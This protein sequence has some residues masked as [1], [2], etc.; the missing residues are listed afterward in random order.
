M[1][2]LRGRPPSFSGQAPQARAGGSARRP[3][4][5]RT[6][7]SEHGLI[8]LVHEAGAETAPPSSG[9]GGRAFTI[10]ADVTAM[11]SVEQAVARTTAEFGHVDILHNNV[12]VTHMGGP[13]ELTEEQ[14]AAA[15]DLNI[16]PVYRT[17]KAVI[18]QALRQGGGAIVNISS[19][20]AARWNEDISILPITR[21]RQR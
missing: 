13:V 2:V 21:P 1:I 9:K 14:F 10:T 8:D 5:L 3:P 18:P 16:G 19:L 7:R 4:S 11:S 6:G 20:A 17:A 12:G 15:L